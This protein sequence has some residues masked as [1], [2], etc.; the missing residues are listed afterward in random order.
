MAVKGADPTVD[1]Y[2][3]IFAQD[4]RKWTPPS[5]YVVPARPD[6][7]NRF[8]TRLMAGDYYAIV[9]DDVE[10]GEWTDP[11]YLARVRDRAT[12][13]SIADGETKSLDLKLSSSR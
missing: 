8:H 9:V 4:P 5:R 12:P 6:R 2:V 3:V 13:F 11:E 1:A 10:P 7:D